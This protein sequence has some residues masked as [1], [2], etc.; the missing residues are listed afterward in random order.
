M[1]WGY[2][3]Y[4]QQPSIVAK[5]ENLCLTK[6]LGKMTSLKAKVLPLLGLLE[7]Q[8]LVQSQSDLN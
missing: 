6:K 7:C 5:M 1:C 2:V 3:S 4:T 8:T